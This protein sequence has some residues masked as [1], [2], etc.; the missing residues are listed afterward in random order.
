ME[1]LVLHIPGLSARLLRDQ[2]AAAVDLA[3]VGGEGA[4]ATLVN[5]E[6]AS[7]QQQEA[8]LLTGL[9]PEYLG[10]FGGGVGPC[11]G[12]PFWVKAAAKRES[13]QSRVRT[14]LPLPAQWQAGA[15][16][17]HLRWETLEQ[18]AVGGAS[19]ETLHAA[20]AAARPWIEQAQAV[21][22]VSAWSIDKRGQLATQRCEPL[23]RPVLL[24]RGID[25]AKATIGILEIAGLLERALTGETVRD[26]LP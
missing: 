16:E 21:V 12:E 24:T 5:L 17:P 26:Q 11:R 19:R 1:L 6:G 4:A 22:V 13:L 23:D 3:R 20:N 8:A 10:A 18:V 2:G 9:L 14:I 25:Q 7:R 15:A